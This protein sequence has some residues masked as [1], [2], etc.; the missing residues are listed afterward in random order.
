MHQIHHESHRNNGDGDGKRESMIASST[1][2]A[3]SGISI[4]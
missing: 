2:E 3:I 4:L 1:L